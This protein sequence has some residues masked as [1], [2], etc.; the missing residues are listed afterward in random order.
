MALCPISLGFFKRL[1]PWGLVI[2][3]A[4]AWFVMFCEKNW[5]NMILDEATRGSGITSGMGTGVH[6]PPYPRL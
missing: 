6:P 3:A 4:N 2:Q 5:R 1:G